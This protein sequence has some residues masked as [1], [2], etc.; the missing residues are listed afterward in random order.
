V[1]EYITCDLGTLANGS[2]VDITVGITPL[3]PGVVT[4]S[5]V[6]TSDIFDPNGVNNIDAEETLVGQYD[7]YLPIMRK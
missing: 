4:N 7:F 5:A 3:G 2:T 1:G 6:V